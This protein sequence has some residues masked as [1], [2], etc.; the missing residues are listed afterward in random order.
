LYFCRSSSV[1]RARFWS[2]LPGVTCC[3]L[4]GELPAQQEKAR[5]NSKTFFILFVG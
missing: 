3:A 5:A 2:F 1:T 4:A